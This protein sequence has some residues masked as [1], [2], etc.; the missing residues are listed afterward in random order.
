MNDRTEFR[1]LIG[2]AR[3]AD[4]YVRAFFTIY[5]TASTCRDNI[6]RASRTFV[7]HGMPT[8]T[9]LNLISSMRI[10][11]EADYFNVLSY[12]TTFLW[13]SMLHAYRATGLCT[14]HT[15]LQALRAF[16]PYELCESTFEQRDQ[17]PRC[18]PLSQAPP[19]SSPWLLLHKLTCVKKK[20]LC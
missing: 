8:S 10:Q 15:H 5:D 1:R 17:R 13:L 3:N 6:Q 2:T 4:D 12:I 18:R 9:E 11:Y 16:H 14:G 20:A 19:L 7:E